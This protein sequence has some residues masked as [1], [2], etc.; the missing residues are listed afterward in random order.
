[1]Y[2]MG[3]WMYETGFGAAQKKGAH[4]RKVDTR[5]LYINL[6]FFSGRSP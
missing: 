3:H 1:M 6:T 5:T 2:Q 4:P